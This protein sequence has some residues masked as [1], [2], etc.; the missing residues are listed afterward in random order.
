MKAFYKLVSSNYRAN[1]SRNQ[2]MT[3][4]SYPLWCDS[5][6]HIRYQWAEYIVSEVF[7][8]EIVFIG[9]INVEV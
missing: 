3:N 6:E 5:K 9:G 2:K 8:D 4:R 7:N 1:R